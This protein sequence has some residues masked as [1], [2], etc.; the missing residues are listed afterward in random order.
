MEQVSQSVSSVDYLRFS[1]SLIYSE[2]DMNGVLLF[3]VVSNV[4]L[5]GRMIP[6]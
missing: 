6:V 5:P 4:V 3:I 1:T 2:E